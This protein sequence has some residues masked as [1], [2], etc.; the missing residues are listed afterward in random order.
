[1]R[2]VE[3]GDEFF[4]GAVA[5]ERGEGWLR[6]WR[7]PANKRDLFISPDDCLLARARESSGVR[8][9]FE[10]DSPRVTLDFAPLETA[11][12]NPTHVIDLT[13]AGGPPISAAVAKGGTSVTF[14][15]LPE[16]TKTIEVWLP[17]DTGIDLRE[18]RIDT[19]AH[20]QAAPDPRP[21]WVTYGSSLTHCRRA[22]SPARTWPA[23]VAR[24]RQL[25][26]TCLGYGG[27]CCLE[28]M[29]GMMIRDLPADF[30]SLKLGI[31]CIGGALAPRTFSAAVMGLTQIIREKK[32]ETPIALIS[33]LAYPPNERTPNAVGN[34]IERMRADIEEVHR[35]LVRRGDRNLYYFN[36]LDL[37]NEAEIADYS[38]DQCH[39]NGDGTELMAEHF[40]E[41]IMDKLNL[42]P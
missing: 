22:H 24:K 14:G 21:K 4:Q 36:G 15:G 38:Q 33:P 6:P 19:G 25:N 17:H 1:M 5:V 9:R 29:V 11:P 34:T 23:I 31:N 41:R 35:R 2:R 40:L 42:F 26:L 28:P 20:C 16:G 10:T 8:L 13:I 32:P 30:I 3:F 39:P 7:I 27:N 37:F 12:I 18:M